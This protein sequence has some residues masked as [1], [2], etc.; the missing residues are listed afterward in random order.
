[1]LVMVVIAV[2][3][4]SHGLLPNESGKTNLEQ[5]LQT[6]NQLIDEERKLNSLEGDYSSKKLECDLLANE[7][8]Y[9]KGTC[10]EDLK[11]IDQKKSEVLRNIVQLR[12]DIGLE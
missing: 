6:G 2:F 10:I 9:G 1:M 11:A 7:Q 5:Y 8:F 3:L 4:V 12:E